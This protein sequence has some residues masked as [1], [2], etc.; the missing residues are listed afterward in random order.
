MKPSQTRGNPVSVC[1][2]QASGPHPVS[3]IFHTDFF[4]RIRFYTQT[5][6]HTKTFHAR[7]LLHIDAF[8]HKN[9]YRTETGHAKPQLYPSANFCI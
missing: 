8:T 5:L 4:T 3:N 9:F 7:R 6:F 2:D 1:I